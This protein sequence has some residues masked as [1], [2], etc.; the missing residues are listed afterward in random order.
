MSMDVPVILIAPIVGAVVCLIGRRS[1]AGIVADF[2]WAVIGATLGAYAGN[3][4][5]LVAEFPW[6]V[7]RVIVE[8]VAAGFFAGVA[9][10]V[11]YRLMRTEEEQAAEEEIRREFGAYR[12]CGTVVNIRAVVSGRAVATEVET[13]EGVFLV[14]GTIDYAKKGAQVWFNGY[15]QMRIDNSGGRTYRLTNVHA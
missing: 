11:I 14:R 13:T 6:R 12:A 1:N 15:S 2:V 3:A 4:L 10:I 5:D 9:N 8:V 7:V